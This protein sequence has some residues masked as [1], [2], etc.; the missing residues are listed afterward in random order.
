MT[1]LIRAFGHSSWCPRPPLGR[2]IPK[3]LILVPEASNADIALIHPKSWILDINEGRSHIAVHLPDGNLHFTF[4]NILICGKLIPGIGGG[5]SHQTEGIPIERVFAVASLNA[6]PH[7]DRLLKALDPVH[8]CLVL[9]LPVFEPIEQLGEL[10][11][12]FLLKVF[13]F[14]GA[15]LQ[16][17]ALEEKVFLVEEQ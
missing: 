12:E 15:G 4:D 6:L 16:L 10:I 1:K 9:A 3:H 17:L 13:T 8:V 5:C 11:F 14:F 7:L 2:R